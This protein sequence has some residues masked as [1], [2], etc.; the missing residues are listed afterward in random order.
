[1]EEI[2]AIDWQATGMKDFFD[3]Y[4]LRDNLRAQ[5]IDW[6]QTSLPEIISRNQAK[7][8]QAETP[9]VKNKRRGL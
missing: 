7:K 4:P 3:Q 5:V 9:K 1:M 8:K 6:D 2:K